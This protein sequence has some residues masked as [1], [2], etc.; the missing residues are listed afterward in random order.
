MP[1][2]KVAGFARW[3]LRGRHVGSWNKREEG[4]FHVLHPLASDALLSPK[5]QDNS[6]SSERKEGAR[7]LTMSLSC[8]VRLHPAS[9]AVRMGQSCTGAHT[10]Q[11]AGEQCSLMGFCP[12]FLQ[13]TSSERAVGGHNP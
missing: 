13:F 11:D 12:L 3:G 10:C 2:W 8:P 5:Q 9:V 6:S 1:G 4:P 7:A